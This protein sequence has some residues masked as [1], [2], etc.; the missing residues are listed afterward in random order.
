[1]KLAKL[2]LVLLGLTL[3][4]VIA[5]R[6]SRED[7]SATGWGKRTALL[8]AADDGDV[9]RLKA[10]IASG[11]DLN[12]RDEWQ[13]TALNLAARN[14]LGCLRILIAAHV[15]INTPGWQRQTAL[16][17]AAAC[18]SRGCLQALISAGA[19]IDERDADGN[20]AL[21]EAVKNGRLP[22]VDTLVNAH[23]N[24]DIRTPFGNSAMLTAAAHGD[25]GSIRA[26]IRAK[27]NVNVRDADGNTPLI[28]ATVN[29]HARCVELLLK[30]GANTEAKRWSK[31]TEPANGFETPPSVGTAL[32]YATHMGR[33]DIVK[34]LVEHGARKL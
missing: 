13:D 26:L 2:I 23:A 20:T 33:G 12:A 4:I 34:L 9:E 22:C 25:A 27:S 28:A 7:I 8:K 1:M 32:N 19:R 3:L 16:I 6:E 21:M 11:A 31:T 29:G 15:D 14:H 24:P 5:V 10:L 17:T 18:G 30:A